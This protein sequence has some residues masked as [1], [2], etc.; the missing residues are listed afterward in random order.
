MAARGAADAQRAERVRIRR[1]T[2]SHSVHRFVRHFR[3]VEDG[4]NM[5]V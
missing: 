4:E 1:A 2:G 3:L 5:S